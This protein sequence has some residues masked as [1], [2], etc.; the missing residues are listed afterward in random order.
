MGW[1]FRRRIKLGPIN[2]NFSRSGVGVSAGAGPFRTGVDAKGRHYTD[3]R[4]SFG[5]YNRQYHTPGAQT[6]FQQA[7]PTPESVVAKDS[8]VALLFSVG[9]LVALFNGAVGPEIQKWLIL[10]H[11]GY[12][13]PRYSRIGQLLW[14]Q[15]RH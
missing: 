5:L 13:Y 6:V 14:P 7:P 2:L 9:A 15:R 3:V 1:S 10:I 11:T 8:L 4:G 12:R